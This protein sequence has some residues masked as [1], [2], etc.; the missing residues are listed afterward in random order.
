MMDAEN[1]EGSQGAGE[2][3]GA[4]AG[5]DF[6]LDMLGMRPGPQPVPEGNP[7]R[8]TSESVEEKPGEGPPERQNENHA[9]FVKQDATPSLTPHSGVTSNQCACK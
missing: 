5:S 3:S 6:H 4:A 1:A 8:Q 7:G 2:K 9:R